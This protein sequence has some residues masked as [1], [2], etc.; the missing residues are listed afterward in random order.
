VATEARHPLRLAV[1]AALAALALAAG[2]VLF[3]IARQWDGMALLAVAA[4]ALLW[5]AVEFRSRF[6]ADEGGLTR[7]SPSGTLTLAWDDIDPDACCLA[8]GL[9][10]VVVARDGAAIS[11]PGG[12]EIA[13]TVR[14]RIPVSACAPRRIWVCAKVDGQVRIA[15]MAAMMGAVLLV[16]LW[17]REIRVTSDPGLG[18]GAVSVQGK[19]LM[20]DPSGDGDFVLTYTYLDAAGV[21]RIGQDRVDRPVAGEIEVRYDPARPDRSRL[22]AS[23]A[24]ARNRHWAK[25]GLILVSVALL[26]AGLAL[27]ISR[28]LGYRRAGRS[29]GARPTPLPPPRPPR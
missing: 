22:E 3:A 5:T 12:G 2:S 1:G 21:T 10:I 24:A 11:I 17:R 9:P 7:S 14:R 15:A 13:S 26:L 8:P 25:S 4:L 29:N 18:A 16:L 27:G 23:V 19:A 6:S 28:L 20:I